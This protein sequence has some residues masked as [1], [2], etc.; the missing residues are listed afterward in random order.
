MNMKLPIPVVT[1]FFLSDFGNCGF[2]AFPITTE[3]MNMIIIKAIEAH[4]LSSPSIGSKMNVADIPA[5][6]ASPT[7]SQNSLSIFFLA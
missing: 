2:I 5:M 6:T 7:L 4:L 1:S 3:I